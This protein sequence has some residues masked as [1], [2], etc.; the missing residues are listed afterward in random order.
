[1]EYPQHR[2]TNKMN[3]QVFPNFRLF[4]DLTATSQKRIE[5][6]VIRI[7]FCAIWV[8][9][10]PVLQTKTISWFLRIFRWFSGFSN[11]NDYLFRIQRNISNILKNFFLIAMSQSFIKNRNFYGFR[12]HFRSCRSFFNVELRNKNL[13]N[14]VLHCIV[15]GK[16]GKCGLVGI[17]NIE[18]LASSVVLQRLIKV[19]ILCF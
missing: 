13:E 1:M 18:S 6:I 2:F 5:I 17:H 14:F 7:S 10:K 15:S 12:K 4:S 16:W 19:F 3:F 9:T 8:P 11:I